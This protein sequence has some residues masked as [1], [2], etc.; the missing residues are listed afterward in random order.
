MKRI[1]VTLEIDVPDKGW[2]TF[3]LDLV[4]RMHKYL[5]K[6]ACKVYK[7]DTEVL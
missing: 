5:S 6:F 7:V 4:K 2:N 1:K 3:H